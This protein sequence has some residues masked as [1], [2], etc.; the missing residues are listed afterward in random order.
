MIKTIICKSLR[1]DEMGIFVKQ[2]ENTTWY[3]LGNALSKIL[4][5]F[6]VFDLIIPN[7]RNY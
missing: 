1:S 2:D 5:T 7:G 3:N 4:K 6:M